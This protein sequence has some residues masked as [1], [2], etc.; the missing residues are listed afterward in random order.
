MAKTM[1]SD[2]GKDLEERFDLYRSHLRERAWY[3]A[4][5]Y[6][7]EISYRSASLRGAQ[8]AAWNSRIEKEELLEEFLREVR[9]GLGKSIKRIYRVLSIGTEWTG[10]E[11]L[12]VMTLRIEIKLVSN[13]LENAIPVELLGH[14]KQIDE[15]LA[16]LEQSENHSRHFECGLRQMKKHWMSDIESIWRSLIAADQ[17]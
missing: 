9:L 11:I 1:T 12:L 17:S 13:F 3:I 5:T 10:E 4:A 7:A 8:R 16:F 15:Q 2:R 6:L 14:L